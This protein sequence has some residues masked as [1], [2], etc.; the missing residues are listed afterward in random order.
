MEFSVISVSTPCLN[1]YKKI[2][3]S[4]ETLRTPL[5]A[6]QI[7]K[8][9]IM[10][11]T[12]CY[13]E[14]KKCP[15]EGTECYTEGRNYHPEGTSVLSGGQKLPSGRHGMLSGGQNLLSGG[16]ISAIRRA[17]ITIRR[18]RQC[19]T[20]AKFY[21]LS[22]PRCPRLEDLQDKK[23]Y[24]FYSFNTENTVKADSNY[25]Y[26]NLFQSGKSLNPVNRGSDNRNTN[27][28]LKIGV[29]HGSK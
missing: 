16:H 24:F 21:P 20:E 27:P 14:A 23:H 13:P 4:L 8:I 6:I 26:R 2:Y 22:E 12:C 9:T 19:Y 28:H 1:E 25:R 5:Q 18:A 10:E 29:H 11:G 3:I 17:E 7:A 15:T